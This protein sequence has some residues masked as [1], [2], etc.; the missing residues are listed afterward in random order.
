VRLIL[1]IDDTIYRITRQL[2]R[3]RPSQAQLHKISATGQ[4]TLLA[5]G[6]K[7]VDQ[8]INSLLNGI[9]LSDL[10]ASNIVLQKDWIV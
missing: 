10:L 2:F 8:E 9:G 5:T 7:N 3:K 1:E 4:S 6:V